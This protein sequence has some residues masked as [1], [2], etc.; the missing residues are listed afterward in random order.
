MIAYAP[1]ISHGVKGGMTNSY[2]VEKLAYSSGYFPTFR[3]HPINGYKFDSKNVDFT[4]Y[5]EFIKMQNR[6]NL[7]T[8][9][10]QLYGKSLDFI[11]QR[12]NYYKNLENNEA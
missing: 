7:L 1:C 3:Y 8:K 9:D 10:N 4:K 5:E 12:Y 6:Y 11:K 2:D